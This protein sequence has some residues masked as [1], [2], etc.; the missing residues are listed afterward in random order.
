MHGRMHQI[1]PQQERKSE[2]IPAPAVAGAILPLP[3]IA[4]A[5]ARGD[6]AVPLK[7]SVSQ[8]AFVDV[9]VTEVK[10]APTLDATIHK[11]AFEERRVV[12]VAE[13][14]EPV[15]LSLPPRPYV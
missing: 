15:L 9:A 11:L 12:L 14:A 13:N 8:L 6:C 4:G 5:F 7:E 10:R 2:H 3:T 1:D